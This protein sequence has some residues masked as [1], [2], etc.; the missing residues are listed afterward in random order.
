MDLVAIAGKVSHVNRILQSV[1]EDGGGGASTTAYE[2]T[3]RIDGQHVKIG[4]ACEWAS[5]GD[6]VAIVGEESD[7]KLL[8]LAIR[9]DTSGYESVTEP[10]FSYGFAIGLIVVG[11]LTLAFMFGFLLIAWG[12]WLIFRIRKNKAL[13]AEAIRRLDAI[14]RA[15]AAS[16][17][18]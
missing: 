5:D 15:S 9:N 13:F 2:T 4:D 17:A 12:M 16:P 18:G 14:P 11:I 6:H 7:G 3:M 1:S 10:R 8:P